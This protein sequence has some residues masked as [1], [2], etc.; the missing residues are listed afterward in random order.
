MECKIK[1]AALPAGQPGKRIGIGEDGKSHKCPQLIKTKE[2]Q[3]HEGPTQDPSQGPGQ[4][5]LKAQVTP[6]AQ[7][8]L[9]NSSSASAPLHFIFFKA[10]MATGA[11]EMRLCSDPAWAAPQKPGWAHKAELSLLWLQSQQPAV[12]PKNP[13][14]NLISQDVAAL[15][16]AAGG[17]RLNVIFCLVLHNP[18]ELWGDRQ[19]R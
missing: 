16:L 1:G 5:L 15:G 18:Q 11:G 13:N 3:G 6:R 10:S 2:H 4:A 8:V 9:L 7:L 12:G 17:W 19:G 14:K